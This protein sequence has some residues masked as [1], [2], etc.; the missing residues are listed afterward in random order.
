VQAASLVDLVF[1]CPLIK[2]FF[3]RELEL[4]RVLHD[5][6]DDVSVARVLVLNNLVLDVSPVCGDL[7]VDRRL[8]RLN[9]VLK[10]F[11]E[12]LERSLQSLRLLE[13]NAHHFEVA[14]L[15][16]LHVLIPLVE[17]VGAL[18]FDSLGLL[19]ELVV[20]DERGLSKLVIELDDLLEDLL[21]ILSV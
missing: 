5:L 17:V 9:P 21:V 12:G 14:R 20:L 16:L 4:I 2:S 10:D 8:H 3:V 11:F 1:E 13:I 15:V 6:L 7:L 19:L 18:R